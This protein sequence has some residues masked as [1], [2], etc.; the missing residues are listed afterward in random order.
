M[1]CKTS[2][3]LLIAAPQDRRDRSSSAIASRID[4][5]N[6]AWGIFVYGL[7]RVARP[8][9][10]MG[11]PHP[12]DVHIGRRMRERRSLLGIS[13]TALGASMGVT[14]QQV[15]KY[16]RGASRIGATRLFE[17]SRRLDVPISFFFENAGA[18]FFKC[19]G[20]PAWP[21]MKDRETLHLVQ[22]F[23]KIRDRQVRLSVAR[24]VKAIARTSASGA[25][26]V[27]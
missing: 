21:P 1:D 6:F 18:L 26:Q 22:D 19:P 10:V 14:F 13:Q 24:M 15:Q 23:F 17:V 12:I 4:C 11:N 5:R 2:S 7:S 3:M 9:K 16:E 27:A 20:Q 25:R 8:R